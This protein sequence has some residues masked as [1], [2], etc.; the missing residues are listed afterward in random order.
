MQLRVSDAAT[1]T[2]DISTDPVAVELGSTSVSSLVQGGLARDLSMNGRDW[3]QL[4]TLEPGVEAILT[5]PD[6]NGVNNRGNRGFGSQVT[7]AGA[8]PYQNNY[9]MDGISVNDYAN[10]T[11]GSTIG[12]TL[13]TESLQE[14]SIIS[15]NY[16]AS[17]GLTSGGVVNSQTRSGSANSMAA[18]SSSCET[19]R[20]MPGGSSTAPSCRS[21]ATSS[22]RR[23]AVRSFARSSFSSLIMRACANR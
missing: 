1:A 7:I 23:P 15:N 21:G 4:A 19:T 8:R 6:P 2:F 3:T 22:A 18:F 20:W 9:R 14:F 16:A 13:G 17:Y 12:L 5:Q 11:P 10:S